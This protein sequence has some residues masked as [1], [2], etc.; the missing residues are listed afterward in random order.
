MKTGIKIAAVLAAFGLIGAP[1]AALA[2]DWIFEIKNQAN[3]TIIGFRTQESGHWSDNWINKPINVGD[4]YE[5]NF[6]HA[7]GDCTVRTQIAFADDSYFDVN[8]NY[9]KINT[10]KIYSKS[11]KGS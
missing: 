8:V 11:V 3:A 6:G 2:E 9:C 10:L 7:D 5:M 4:A 1:V